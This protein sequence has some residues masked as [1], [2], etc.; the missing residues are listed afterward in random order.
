MGSVPASA[1]S[2]SGTPPVSISTACSTTASGSP[3]SLC[4]GGCAIRAGI[5]RCSTSSRI[6]RGARRASGRTCA[7]RCPCAPAFWRST[8]RGFR[9]RGR[10]RW[11]VQRPYCGALGKI[12]NCQVAVSSALIADGRTWPLA[13]D[14]YV[15]V[16]WTD[17]AARRTAA[18]IPATLQFREKWRIALAQVRA[19]LQ[20]GFT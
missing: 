16:S 19:I 1:A 12:G 17:D 4:M 2:R 9:R 18:G 5:R 15:P 6:P 8:T 10:A 13:F 11:G 3:C 14:L 20:A 7:R